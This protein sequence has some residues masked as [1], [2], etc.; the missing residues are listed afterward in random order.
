MNVT[1]TQRVPVNVDEF[2]RLLNAFPM[3]VS[4]C[5][6]AMEPADFPLPT[7]AQN[8]GETLSKRQVFISCPF[9]VVLC[10]RLSF[11]PQRASP[12]TTKKFQ[13]RTRIVRKVCRGAAIHGPRDRRVSQPMPFP[14]PPRSQVVG[15]VLVYRIPFEVEVAWLMRALPRKGWAESKAISKSPTGNGGDGMVR[16]NCGCPWVPPRETQPSCRCPYSFYPR[17]PFCRQ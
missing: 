11:K 5:M 10:S 4:T 8:Q 3:P 13:S 6:R 14:K 1:R 2:H 16:P 12:V 9:Q 7:T 15:Y 17:N